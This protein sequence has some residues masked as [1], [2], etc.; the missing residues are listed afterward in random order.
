MKVCAHN[1]VQAE[2]SLCGMACDAYVSGDSDSEYVLA[3]D[4]GKS[5]N[6]EDCKRVLSEL[7]KTYTEAGR[8]RKGTL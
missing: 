1:P 8:L 2:Y 6:C 7:F 5:V 3:V 4:S